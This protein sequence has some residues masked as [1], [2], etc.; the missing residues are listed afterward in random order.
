LTSMNTI[1]TSSEAFNPIEGNQ[2]DRCAQK[3]NVFRVQVKAWKE[4]DNVLGH[5]TLR[6]RQAL[7]IPFALI[8][9]VCACFHCSNR[10]RASASARVLEQISL[11]LNR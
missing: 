8:S 3:A 5:F 9:C 1:S 11:G 2:V 6:D 10:K 4:W 7:L